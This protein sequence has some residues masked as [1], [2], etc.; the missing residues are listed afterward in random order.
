MNWF[1]A[2]V[3]FLLV[4]WTLLF[5]VLPL[6]TRPQPEADEATGWRGVPERPMMLRKLLVT[7]AISIVVWAAIMWVIQSP[8]LSFRASL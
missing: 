7:T 3:V 6:W 2:F 1:T 5:T 8:Y 4:W